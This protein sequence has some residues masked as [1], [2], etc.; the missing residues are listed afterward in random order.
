MR[1]RNEPKQPTEATEIGAS[2]NSMKQNSSKTV[3]DSDSKATGR[4]SATA[5]NQQVRK[6]FLVVAIAVV[7]RI[8]IWKFSEGRSNIT[9]GKSETQSRL[10]VTEES[11]LTSQT[12]LTSYSSLLEAKALIQLQQ[13]GSK[14]PSFASPNFRKFSPYVNDIVRVPPIIL[15]LLD[16]LDCL[17]SRFRQYLFLLSIEVLTALVLGVAVSRL[18]RQRE[19]RVDLSVHVERLESP[20]SPSKQL[21]SSSSVVDNSVVIKP[22]WLVN[23]SAELNQPWIIVAIYLL[24]PLNVRIG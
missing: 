17:S 18:H 6:S 24:N 1:N 10:W 20:S 16:S 21:D 23:H 12:P 2:Q 4:I 9:G 14:T 22:T 7:L 8:A 15:H 19:T 11:L 13:Q 3:H 5:N